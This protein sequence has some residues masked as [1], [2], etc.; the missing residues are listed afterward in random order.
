MYVNM[1]D[2]I[3]DKNNKAQHRTI[4][5]NSAKVKVDTYIDHDLE[6]NDK[7]LKFKVGYH[8]RIPKYKTIFAKGL[9]RY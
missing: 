1:L 3:I 6:H 7:D 9:I 4:K 2:E 5:Q 8:V